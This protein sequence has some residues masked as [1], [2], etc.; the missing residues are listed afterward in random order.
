M[1][2]PG[3]P[4]GNISRPRI[5]FLAAFALLV[6]AIVV[7]PFVNINRFRHSIVQ[8]ISAGLDRPVY[9]NSVELSLFPRPA[10]VLHHLTISEWPEYSAEPVI[11]AE[12]VT[13]NLRAST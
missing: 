2:N 13:A 11:T 5:Y 7:P 10:F 12:T 8:S 1:K 4:A 9:A 3:T 6:L